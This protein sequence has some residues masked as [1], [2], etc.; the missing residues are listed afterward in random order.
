MGK[1]IVVHWLKHEQRG[2]NLY[3]ASF[4]PK[5]LMELASMSVAM[6]EHCLHDL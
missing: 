1:L 3:A 2:R 6:C 5:D 4:A